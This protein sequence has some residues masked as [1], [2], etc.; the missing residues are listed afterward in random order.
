MDDLRN[1][2]KT[3]VTPILQQQSSTPQP[4]TPLN[5][6]NIGQHSLKGGTTKDLG[7]IASTSK[8]GTTAK[9]NKLSKKRRDAIQKKQD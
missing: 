4:A 3:T 8:Q 9:K 2:F 1:D 6:S 5:S 7:S